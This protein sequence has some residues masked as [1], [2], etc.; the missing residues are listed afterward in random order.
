MA[1]LSLLGKKRK[2]PTNQQPVPAWF[3][4]S[5]PEWQVYYA[6]L[7]LGYKNRFTYQSSQLGGR[8]ARGGAVI[9][10]YISELSL[11]INVQSKYFHYSTTRKLV[12]NI[13]QKAQLESRGIKMVFVNEEDVLRDPIYFVGEALSFREH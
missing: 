4:G 7:K 13:L 10:F 3:V 2:E 5:I 11:G 12:A 1:K 9:D 6:L 8:Q